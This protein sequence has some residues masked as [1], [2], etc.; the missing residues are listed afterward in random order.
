M[1][2]FRC[3]SRIPEK[4]SHCPEALCS[5]N[6]WHWNQQIGTIIPETPTPE[7]DGS[8]GDGPGAKSLGKISEICFCVV[9]VTPLTPIRT[10]GGYWYCCYSGVALCPWPWP[11]PFVR[12]VASPRAQGH[13]RRPK[14]EDLGQGPMPRP[15][16]WALGLVGVRGLAR[17]AYFFPGARGRGGL[18]P[19]NFVV[20]CVRP[21]FCRETSAL[22][23]AQ[24]HLPWPP[25][26]IIFRRS[27]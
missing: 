10:F 3:L 16:A 6:F 5:V 12:C 26:N 15:Q 20:F 27:S 11:W 2:Y 24:Q 19:G 23:K 8:N 21:F 4:S 25:P 18:S 22:V 17:T 14:P 13:G 1:P 7:Q 9:F